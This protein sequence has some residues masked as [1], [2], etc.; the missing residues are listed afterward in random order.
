METLIRVRKGDTCIVAC[1]NA[2]YYA[3]AL[4][5][6]IATKET[7]NDRYTYPEIFRFIYVACVSS[8]TNTWI[9]SSFKARTG[10]DKI[11]SNHM[12]GSFIQYRV[13]A[14]PMNLIPEEI[15]KSITEF[16]NKFKL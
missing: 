15:Q 5:D 11:Y 7:K 1:N 8:R 13:L 16:K 9:Y 4:E 14:Y 6:L 12:T 3:I 10:Y 2:M